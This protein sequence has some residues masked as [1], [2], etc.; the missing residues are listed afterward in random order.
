MKKTLI[1]VLALICYLH[2]H[3]QVQ[4]KYDVVSI[5][6]DNRGKV[7]ELSIY[8]HSISDVKKI[9]S[10]LWAKYKNTGIASF[11]IF[12]YDNKQIAKTYSQLLFNKK[13]SDSQ[14]DKIS[15]HVVGKFE[16]VLGKEN[17]YVGEDALLY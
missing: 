13:I 9:N 8:V 4:P 16:C 12:Y 6:K 17:L 7:N 15:R 3:A 14:M 2:I 5:G 11:Q 1:I 10:I